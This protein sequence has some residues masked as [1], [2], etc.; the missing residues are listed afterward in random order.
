MNRWPSLD[1]LYTGSGFFLKELISETQK[2]NI[3]W[4]N[5]DKY[6]MGR[7][8]SVIYDE[9]TEQLFLVFVSFYSNSTFLYIEKVENTV[10]SGIRFKKKNITVHDIDYCIKPIDPEHQKGGGGIRLD[11]TSGS[12]KYIYELRRAIEK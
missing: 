11:F 7:Y 6:D 10:I 4:K 2:G 8:H 5:V 3:L 9:L 1:V 12:Q